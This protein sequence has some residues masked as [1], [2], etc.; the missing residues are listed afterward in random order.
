MKNIFL[1]LKFNIQKNCV[2][3]IMIHHFFSE[4]IELGKIEKLVATL[5]DKKEYVVHIKYSK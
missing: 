4:R 3:L 2:N 1:K 5:D